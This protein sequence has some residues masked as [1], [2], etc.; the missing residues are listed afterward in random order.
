M[1]R[2][3]RWRSRKIFSSDGPTWR[4]T[5][6]SQAKIFLVERAV[7]ALAVDQ[8]DAPGG[9]VVLVESDRHERADAKFSLGGA[10]K[11][12]EILDGAAVAA[13]PAEAGAGSLRENSSKRGVHIVEQEAVG[14]GERKAVWA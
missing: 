4:A 6:S 7:G 13:V 5:R 9:L 12:R 3:R 10:R 1:A 8:E 2:A 14:A 11:A